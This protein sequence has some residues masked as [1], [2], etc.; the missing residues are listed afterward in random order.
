LNHPNILAVYQLGTHDGAP[1]LITELLEGETLRGEVSRS[2]LSMRKVVD[3]AVQ[4][5]RGLAAAHEKGIVH[6]DLKPENVFVTRDGRVKILDFGLAKLTPPQERPKSGVPTLTEGTNP[7]VVLGTI[8]YMSPEQVRGERSDHRTDIFAFGTILYE[9]L[10]GKRAFQKATSADTMSAI[11]NEDPPSISQIVPTASPALLRVV[12]RC[13]EKKPEQR[14]QSA[15]DLAFALE[16][17]SGTGSGPI[18]M[19]A[20][21]RQGRTWKWVAAGGIAIASAAALIA[22]KWLPPAVPHVGA[23]IQLT[24]DGVPKQGRLVSD[25]SRVYFN[26]GEPGSWR[27]AQVSVH[28]GQTASIPTR[29]VNPHIAALAPDG[30]ALLASVGG[31]NDF[32]DPLWLIPLPAGEPRRLGDIEASAANFFPDGRI[33]FT[34]GTSLFVAETDGSSPRKV[35][36]ST[37]YLGT[38][39]V[40]PDGK[41]VGFTTWSG[42]GSVTGLR[43]TAVDGTRQ[44]EVLKTGADFPSPRFGTWTP[45]GRYRLFQNLSDGR[46][47]LWLLPEQIGFFQRLQAPLRLTNGP[48]SYTDASVSRD[49]KQVFVIGSQR[50]GE[51]IRYDEKFHEFVPFLSGISATDATF[52]RDGKWVAY[53]SYPDCTLWRSR[54]DGSDRLQLTYPPTVVWF[55]NISPDGTEVVYSTFGNFVYISKMSGGTPRKIA[56]QSV[57]ANWSPDGKLLVLSTWVPNK[58]GGEKNIVQLQILDLQ[59][60]KISV[61]PDSEGKLGAYWLDQHTLVAATRDTTKLLTFDLTTEKWAELASGVFVNWFISLDRKYLYCTTGGGEP[62]ALRIR[63]SDHKAETIVSL[64]DLRRVVDPYF[65]TQ[66]GVAPDGSVLL[67]RDVGTEEIYTLEVEWP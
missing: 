57:A 43:E 27:I 17:L 26:E 58:H 12:Q 39:S 22:W 67:T 32:A 4:M 31:F 64:K 6:R 23:V 8:G 10:A 53:R 66:V 48:L 40:S 42:V 14:F 41:R 13:L 56:E 20:P 19:G 50:R 18:S 46:S 38:P 47:D 59:S 16:A 25:G 1:Y 65:G 60:D 11:L 51:L 55:P 33:V 45:D 2:R 35:L 7:G 34:Q 5:A 29:L 15:S 30:S 54:S 44:Q 63:F 37:E 28:G 49:G 3:Y 52:S 62:K 36:D 21:T 9:M 24:D 61:I